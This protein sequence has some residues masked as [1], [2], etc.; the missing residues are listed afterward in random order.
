VL[1][2]AWLPDYFENSMNG[3]LHKPPYQISAR[4]RDPQSRRH[5]TAQ[6]HPSEVAARRRPWITEHY[7]NWYASVG[8]ARPARPDDNER[9]RPE[10]DILTGTS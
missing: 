3:V 7:G 8:G 1:A 10:R 2:I 9:Q 6:R 5:M 4:A